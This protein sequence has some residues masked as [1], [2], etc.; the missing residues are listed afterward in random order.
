MTASAG[1]SSP[2]V[3]LLI[4]SQASILPNNLP[5][6]AHEMKTLHEFCK[7]IKVCADKFSDVL[8]FF[9]LVWRL[10]FDVYLV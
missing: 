9:I 5:K 1:M 2:N 8:I 10:S 4:G 6:T 7:L 3:Q